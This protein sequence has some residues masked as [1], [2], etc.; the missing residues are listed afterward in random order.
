MP[1]EDAIPDLRVAIEE[2]LRRGVAVAFGA[3]VAG[4][5]VGRQMLVWKAGQTRGNLGWPRLNQ[6]AALYA[7]QLLERGPQAARKVF[8]QQGERIEVAFELFLP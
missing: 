1:R 2:S 5:G 7:E 8:D 3:V 6:R 4:P